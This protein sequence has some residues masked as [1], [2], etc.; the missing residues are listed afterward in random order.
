MNTE[1]LTMPNG[2]TIDA[3]LIKRFE[4]ILYNNDYIRYAQDLYYGQNRLFIRKFEYELH[5]VYSDDNEEWET[6]MRSEIETEIL[7]EY[8]VIPEYDELLKK[9][10]EAEHPLG[11]D[12]DMDT[13]YTDSL[14]KSRNHQ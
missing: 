10:F 8:V 1:K 9:S 14:S 4:E 2:E 5:P 12:Y 6:H 11:T 7:C 3:V 13:A